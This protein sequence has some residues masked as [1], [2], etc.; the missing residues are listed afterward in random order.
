MTRAGLGVTC[1]VA[2]VLLQST[3]ASAV[4]EA[5][6][7]LVLNVDRCPESSGDIR[8]IVEVELR[9]SV[10]LLDAAGSAPPDAAA[11]GVTTVR[12]T[13][14]DR[15]ASIDIADPVTG[16]TLQRTVALEPVAPVARAHLI[17]LSIVELLL[18]SWSELLSDAEPAARPVGATAAP[19]TRATA[20]ELVR[21]R[22]QHD[23][24]PWMSLR[25]LAVGVVSSFTASKSLGAE[26]RLYGGALVV[27]GDGPRHLGWM[28][29]LTFQHG[30]RAFSQ[31]QVSADSLAALAAA[32]G[33]W[34]RGRFVLRGGIGLR[35]GV[36]WLGGT[37]VD[38]EITVGGAVRGVW[39]GPAALVDGGLR[40]GRRGVIA[41]AVEVGRTQLPVTA[42]VQ[43]D[44]PV[45]IGGTWIRA[46]LG[47]GFAR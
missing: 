16:K 32:V 44:N 8:N 21:D 42:F 20:L 6:A 27:T 25:L 22:A 40:V 23:G 39:W 45:V 31:G 34:S 7:F 15:V 10:A 43:G 46:G 47:V 13:C 17:A 33:H 3:P 19:E 11:P 26:P 28:A 29:D 12:V 9:R 41:I 4:P 5:P 36:A 14:D 35:A 30:S 1:A 38:P 24:A 2:G 37:P 18:A